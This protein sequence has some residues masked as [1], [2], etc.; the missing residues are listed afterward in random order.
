MAQR[1]LKEGLDQRSG[2]ILPPKPGGYSY[3]E[4]FTDNT[5]NDDP[6]KPFAPVELRVAILRSN[7]T[8]QRPAHFVV[9]EGPGAR[10]ARCR[11]K[12]DDPNSVAISVTRKSGDGTEPIVITA[13]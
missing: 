2:L 4:A 3:F 10:P 6:V 12:L 9:G 7:M 13:Y 11:V 1:D 8:W 5:L